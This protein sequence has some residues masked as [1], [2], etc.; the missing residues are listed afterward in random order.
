MYMYTYTYV[1]CAYVCAYIYIEGVT[2][3]IT[4]VVVLGSL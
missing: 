2:A 4:N 1:H 3:I